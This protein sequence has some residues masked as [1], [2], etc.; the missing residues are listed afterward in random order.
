MIKTDKFKTSSVPE[1]DFSTA[2]E[3][4][5]YLREPEQMYVGAPGYSNN[6]PSL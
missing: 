4:R 3:M 5:P 1:V 6:S 2:R